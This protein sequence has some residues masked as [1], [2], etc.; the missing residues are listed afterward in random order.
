MYCWGDLKMRVHPY[1]YDLDIG[2]LLVRAWVRILN[3]L[4]G[5]RSRE[6][7]AYLV[8]NFSTL[9]DCFTSSNYPIDQPRFKALIEIPHLEVLP[10][11][12]WSEYIKK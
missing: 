12:L 1:A 3:L 8:N 2:Q 5:L 10:P 4:V 7:I 6:A 9:V 11:F